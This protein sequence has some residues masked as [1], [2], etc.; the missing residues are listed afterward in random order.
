MPKALPKALVL[1]FI[2]SEFFV[3]G[4]NPGKF[5]QQVAIQGNGSDGSL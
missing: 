5:S 2:A 1:Q 4:V 3:Y